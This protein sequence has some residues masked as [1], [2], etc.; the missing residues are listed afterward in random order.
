MLF[1]EYSS[2][3]VLRAFPLFL[4]GVAA[5]W[6][7]K[8][9]GEVRGDAQQLEQAFLARFTAS[10]FTCWVKVSDTFSRTYQASE[11]FD[12]NTKDIPGC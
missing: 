5:D 1:S 3:G 6:Y 8:L 11:T 4:S 10:D 9:S 2:D 7:D 12:T